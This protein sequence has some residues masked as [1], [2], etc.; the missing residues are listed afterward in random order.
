M[1]ETADKCAF[2]SCAPNVRVTKPPVAFRF[3]FAYDS[4]MPTALV[5]GASRGVG[6]GIAI[7]LAAEGFTVFATGRTIASADLPPAIVRIPCD[8]CDDTET[9]RT[10]Q[11]VAAS[12]D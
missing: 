2:K 1:V 10:F 12:G 4:F 5:T 11:Q 3:F 6:R 7:A 8:H 9:A